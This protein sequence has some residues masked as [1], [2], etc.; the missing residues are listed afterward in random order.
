MDNIE[1]SPEAEARDL[2]RMMYII[3]MSLPNG[4]TILERHL[5]G[6]P[7]PSWVTERPKRVRTKS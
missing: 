1:L 7:L 2:V 3:I 5:A 4:S 6:D